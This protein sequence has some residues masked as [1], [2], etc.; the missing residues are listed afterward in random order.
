MGY[1]LRDSSSSIRTGQLRLY[2]CIILITSM[3]ILFVLTAH[4][5]DSFFEI[6]LATKLRQCTTF[7][8][9]N[10]MKD[11]LS[12]IKSIYMVKLHI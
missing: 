1:D 2:S 4:F 12:R 10:V 11:L 5:H 7:L 3:I 9:S 6:I 8:N